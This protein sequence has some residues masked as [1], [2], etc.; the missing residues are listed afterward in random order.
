[1]VALAEA[2]I[3]LITEAK[4]EGIQLVEF[5]IACFSFPDKR[6]INTLLFL[7]RLNRLQHFVWIFG[8]Y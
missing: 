1:M 4:K 3:K 6:V 8:L 2:N 7:D 5:T